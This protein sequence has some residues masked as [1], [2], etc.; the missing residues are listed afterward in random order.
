M[1]CGSCGARRKELNENYDIMGGYK[2]LSDRQIRARLEVFKKKFCHNCNERFNC[3]YEM[4]ITCNN[5]VT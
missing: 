1:G 4:F 3:N 2:Y 5:K